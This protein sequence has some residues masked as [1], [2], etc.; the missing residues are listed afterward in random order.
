MI[1]EK[2]KIV[3]EYLNEDVIL[4]E[5]V[6][7]LLTLSLKVLRFWGSESSEV[8]N[9][10]K[11]WMIWGLRK[12]VSWPLSLDSCPLTLVPCP[13][14]LDPW[15]LT[16]DP[17]PLTLDPWLLTLVPWPLSLDSCPL[18]LVPCPLTLDSCPLSLDPCPLTLNPSPTKHEKIYLAGTT[19]TYQRATNQTA[20]TECMER[21]GRKWT[22]HGAKHILWQ[23]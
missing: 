10:L 17:W 4:A 21:P 15:P 1:Q 23:L 6:P 20:N 19:I 8:L 11:F 3:L 13:L 7:R 14:T 18:T 12:L 9:D 22:T 2:E 16:L 5:L